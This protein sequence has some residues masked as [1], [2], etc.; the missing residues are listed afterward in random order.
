MPAFGHIKP[1][2]RY[3]CS[4]NGSASDVGDANTISSIRRYGDS[5]LVLDTLYILFD[6]DWI[7]VPIGSVGTLLRI[8]DDAVAL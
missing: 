7:V 2:V 3:N 1:T 8:T 4:S 5:R 6:G